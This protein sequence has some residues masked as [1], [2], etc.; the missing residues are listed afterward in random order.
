MSIQ[1]SANFKRVFKELFKVC[2]NKVRVMA[3]NAPEL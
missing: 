3:E 2:Q 1:G